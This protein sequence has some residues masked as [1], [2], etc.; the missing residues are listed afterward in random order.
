[1]GVSIPMQIY[2]FIFI[3]VSNHRQ[4]AEG[5][6]FHEVVQKLQPQLSPA[7]ISARVCMGQPAR[8]GKF[9]M[10][11]INTATE[12]LLLLLLSPFLSF[13]LS[14]SLTLSFIYPLSSF[15][16]YF[17][18]AFCVSMLLKFISLVNRMAPMLLSIHSSWIKG[19]SRFNPN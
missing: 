15:F 14:Q 1:M 7:P 13:S 11:G 6:F 17:R 9:D 8:K 5:S 3:Y 4:A 18:C 19:I 10:K 16:F 2:I 12:N